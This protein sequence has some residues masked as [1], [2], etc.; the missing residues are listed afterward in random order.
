MERW[1]IEQDV[2]DKRTAL[3]LS[4]VMNKGVFDRL[5]SVVSE[6]KESVVFRAKRGDKDVC[7]KIYKVETSPFIHKVKYIE[8]DPRFKLVKKTKWDVVRVFVK[9]EFKNLQILH[10][11]SV[12]VPKPLFFYN[13]VIVMEF[14]G[15]NG[16]PYPKLKDVKLNKKHVQSLFSSLWKMAHAGFAHTD[17]SA[18]NVLA[19]PTKTFIIDLGQGVTW[20]HPNFTTFFL[21]DVNNVTTFVNKHMNVIK[22]T[23]IVKAFT[24]RLNLLLRRS[25]E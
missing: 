14:L 5:E 4:H 15:E 22:R 2:F 18:Y 1:K 6:G 10:A 13:N 17:L 9:K 12:P 20:R 19:T 7:V 23:D 21:R 25:P 16:T 8:G 3:S 11:L 24:K